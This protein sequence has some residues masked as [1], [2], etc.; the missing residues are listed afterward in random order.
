VELAPGPGAL[1]DDALHRAQ[2]ELSL[3]RTDRHG[4]IDTSIQTRR[5]RRTVQIAAANMAAMLPTSFGFAATDQ[6][7]SAELDQDLDD[8][9]AY[10][11]AAAERATHVAEIAEREVTRRTRLWD[12]VARRRQER[13]TLIQTAIIGTLLM[14]LTAIQALSYRVPLPGPAKPALIT[15][16]GAAV[17]WLSVVAVRLIAAPV[18]RRSV[19]CGAFGAFVAALTWLATSW[20]TGP[21]PWIPKGPLATTLMSA[22]GLAAGYA[23]AAMWARRPSA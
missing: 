1:G 12:G 16:L 19:E 7:I 13:F 21:V 5:M 9:G 2:D 3:L 8:L 11:D 22:A 23:A 14:V 10:L 15:T 4:I 17:L 20:F 6:R 18:Y